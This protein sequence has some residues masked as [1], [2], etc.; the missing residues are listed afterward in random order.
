MNK[1]IK[2]NPDFIHASTFGQL[3]QICLLRDAEFGM[4]QNSHNSFDIMPNDQSEFPLQS[5]DKEED[6][7]SAFAFR[8]IEREL[9]TDQLPLFIKVAN[10]R[11]QAGTKRDCYTLNATMTNPEWMK[12]F[13][14][15]GALIGRTMVKDHLWFGV[16]M[17]PTFWMLVQDSE[18]PTLEDFAKEDARLRKR[19]N[20]FEE[21][22]K[23]GVW[24]DDEGFFWTT[25]DDKI[26]P[27]DRE[28]PQR[29]L[30][31]E[32]KEELI[33]IQPVNAENYQQFRD[34]LLDRLI[35]E[36]QEQMK[37]IKVGIKQSLGDFD[38]LRHYLN[39]H[40]L[41]DLTET[42]QDVNMYKQY[43]GDGIERLKENTIYMNCQA[44]DEQIKMFWTVYS[45]L[46][47]ED[48]K[49]YLNLV[50]G[51]SRLGDKSH[52]YAMSHRIR[53][54][55]TMSEGEMPKSK[56][57]QFELILAPNYANADAMKAKLL[58]AINKGCGL[59]PDQD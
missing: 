43:D 21:A 5:G 59:E 28:Q 17:A 54:D 25:C 55:S 46:N 35:T 14:M 16:P 29:P 18:L 3:F 53:I 42:K 1:G 57:S 26:L 41:M 2:H 19:L 44:E 8:E 33:G 10:G 56:A 15:I 6:N 40:D 49:G 50:S 20:K 47:Y 13:Q 51:K 11:N 34:Q 7:A 12:C 48:K 32:A 30:S 22:Q 38:Y 45:A 58:T 36:N 9:M 27:I 52:R 39:W 31:N 37:H 4:M 23:D 24:P